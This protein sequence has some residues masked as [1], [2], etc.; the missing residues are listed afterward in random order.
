MRVTG[1]EFDWDEGNREKCQK[2][3]LS[4]HEIESLFQSPL[5]VF[6]DSE[7]SKLEERFIGIGK[8]ESG[9]GVL[10]VFTLRMRGE[11]IL[12]RPISARYMHKKEI[13]HY[14]KET[15]QAQKRR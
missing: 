3:G 15:S 8:T 13:E 7:H 2:H 9:R 6:P 5:S 11:A 12:I 4:T 14:E 10:I 1:L